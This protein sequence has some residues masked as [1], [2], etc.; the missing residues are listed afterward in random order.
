MWFVFHTRKE[1]PQDRQSQ[2]RAHSWKKLRGLPEATSGTMGVLK[3]VKTV[4]FNT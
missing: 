1:A 3:G 4:T 2:G